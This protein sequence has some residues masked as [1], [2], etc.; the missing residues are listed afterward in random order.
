MSTELLLQRYAAWSAE[1]LEKSYFILNFYF[2]ISYAHWR[3]AP[4]WKLQ[5]LNEVAHPPLGDPEHPAAVQGSPGPAPRHTRRSTTGS[6][7]QTT[8]TTPSHQF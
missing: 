1:D 8:R 5:K 6:R 3:K 4:P 7:Q 2:K